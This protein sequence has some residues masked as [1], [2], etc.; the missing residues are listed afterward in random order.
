MTFRNLV[1]LAALGLSASAAWA[2]PDPVSAVDGFH[3]ALVRN[4]AAA[5]TSLLAA[6]ALIFEAGHVERSA[7]E[8]AGGHLAGDAAHAAK[9]AT[10]YMGRRCLIGMEMTLV[11]TETLSTPIGGGDVR[12]G[13]ETMLLRRTGADWRIAH[14]HWSSRK[15]APGKTAP[16]SQPAPPACPA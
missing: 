8:Y 10:R 7:K 14:I 13:T 11:A 15:L 2:A 16:A 4:D 1:T 3:Q 9:T 5:A 6:D 12:I